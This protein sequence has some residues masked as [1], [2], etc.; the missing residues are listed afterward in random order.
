MKKVSVDNE[1]CFGC[2]TCVYLDPE[3][4]SFDNE[5][6]ISKVISESNVENNDKL[7]E[8]IESCP[9]NAI[10]IFE[11]DCTNEKCTCNPCN[12]GADCKCNDID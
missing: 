6:G 7:N 2:G 9:V 8:A 11:T 4:F 5:S 1:R 3:H 12:C 10:E